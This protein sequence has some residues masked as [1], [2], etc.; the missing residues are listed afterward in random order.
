MQLLFKIRRK[1]ILQRLRP[2]KR[3]KKRPFA[4]AQE[5]LAENRN[6]AF[7]ENEY[8]INSPSGAK[9]LSA[10]TS[11]SGSSTASSFRPGSKENE[12]AVYYSIEDEEEK[13]KEPF[14]VT[15]L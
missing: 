1:T 14:D 3:R 8:V 2:T 4:T 13:D 12:S 7:E 15:S 5:L 10:G 9:E 11:A 6:E